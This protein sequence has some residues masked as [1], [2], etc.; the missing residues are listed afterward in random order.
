VRFILLLLLWSSLLGNELKLQYKEGK[1]FAKQS[2]STALKEMELINPN[3]CLPNE[4]KGKEFNGKEAKEKIKE[5]K[6]PVTQFTQ[7]VNPY[8][9][10]DEFLFKR[11][12]ELTRDQN[13]PIFD[14]YIEDYHTE[15]CTEADAPFNLTIERSL[16]VHVT[17]SPEEKI[18]IKKC[19]GHKDKTHHYWKSDA[20]KEKKKQ[21][22]RLSADPTIKSYSVKIKGG[23]FTSDYT[24]RWTWTHEENAPA[25]SVYNTQNKTVKNESWEEKDHW[26]YANPS[27][28]ALAQSTQCT[29]LGSECLDSSAT[30]TIHG[31]QIQRQCWQEKLRYGCRFDSKNKCEFLK[32]KNCLLEYKECIYASDR[33]CALWKMMF[34]CASKRG[35]NE[36]ANI[37]GTI[38][39][40][41]EDWDT[42]HDPNTAFSDIAT[43]LSIFEELK[44]ELEQSQTV[45]ATSIQLFKGKKSQC[46][47]SVAENAMY[48]C[49]FSYKG[50]ANEMKLSKCTTEE[51]ALEDM[52][53]R[54]L[55]HYIGSYEEKFLDMWKS[56]TEYVY[57]CF[58][59][60]LSRVF[61]EQ[62]R[63]QL[64]IDWGSPRHPDC[65]G[66]TQEE[67]S[68]IDFSKLDLSEAFDKIPHS[69]KAEKSQDAFKN[70][71]RVKLM[72]EKLKNRISQMN[73][74]TN[75]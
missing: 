49:C 61:Q 34:K 31:R 65:R 40:T 38:G 33:G 52:R 53:S 7:P 6:P 55:C 35:K 22:A 1:D 20:E 10:E 37:K 73:S 56:R 57:C 63:K 27:D 58:P 39:T 23:K 41:E 45:D 48:D 67:L 25:C 13:G 51:I 74:G 70:E 2:N 75:A 24:V 18:Q 47:K 50:L 60:K 19:K 43:T 26:I 62:A 32:H 12:D 14:T 3:D 42:A 72:E 59:S 29:Y 15:S 21:E 11:S 17:Y 16:D 69:D 44:H 8:F 54:G 4:D 9:S 68:N 46:A 28:L 66:L 36:M 71:D 5:G 64:K 30:K